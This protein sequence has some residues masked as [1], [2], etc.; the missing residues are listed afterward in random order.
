MSELHAQALSLW[1]TW[2][3]IKP[4]YVARDRRRK[5]YALRSRNIAEGRHPVS[6]KEASEVCLQIGYNE[7][8][9]WFHAMVGRLSATPTHVI[10]AHFRERQEKGPGSNEQDPF[11][12]LPNF[13]S[14]K[15]E[16]DD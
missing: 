16:L 8:S 13:D 12:D 14:L 10:K 11:L 15:I 4:L 1:A 5:V 2:E 6:I 9:N 7:R 3:R